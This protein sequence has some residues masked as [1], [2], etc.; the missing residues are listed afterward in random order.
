MD[1]WIATNAK[2]REAVQRFVRADQNRA[3][4]TL[5]RHFNPK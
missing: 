3:P 4:V 2:Y 1:S 5:A